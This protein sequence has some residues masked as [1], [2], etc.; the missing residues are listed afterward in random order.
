MKLK[1][2]QIN[3]HGNPSESIFSIDFQYLKETETFSHGGGEEPMI[4]FAT[5]GGDHKV[6]VI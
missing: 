3:W 2:V 4:R 5:A 6:R 1:T